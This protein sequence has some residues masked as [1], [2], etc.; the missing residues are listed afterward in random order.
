MPASPAA[1]VKEEA[2]IVA[3]IEGTVENRP[4]SQPPYS[5]FSPARKKFILSIVVAKSFIAPVSAGIYMPLLP[6]LAED[7]N[8]SPTLINLTVTV[9]MLTFAVAPLFF[10]SLSDVGGRKPVYVLG[11]SIGIGANIAL[12]SAPAHYASFMVLRVIQAFGGSALYSLG[13]GTV[14][15]I[16]EPKQR[17]RAIS[18]YSLGPQLGPILG[19]V[20]G[21]LIAQ[22]STW[23][24]TFGFLAIFGGFCLLVSMFL[25]PETL[26]SRVGNG[27][28][29]DG[30]PWIQWPSFSERAEP[31]AGEVVLRRPSR[32]NIPIFMK[33][34]II[35]FSCIN[36][37]ILF[38]SYYCL[39][40]AFPTVLQER[41][42][43]NSGKIGAAYLAPG[44]SMTCGSVICGHLSD[45]A[46]RRHL[47]KTETEEAA[48]ERRLHL[49]FIGTA[50][51]PIGVLIY[52]WLGNFSIGVSGVIMSMAICGFA[53]S[54]TLSTNTT[55]V[56]L[57][58]PGQAATLVALTSLLRNPA[59]AIGAAVI[60]PLIK[61]EGFGWCFTGLAIFDLISTGIALLSLAKGPSWR[62]A[63]EKKH[64]RSIHR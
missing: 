2:D 28:I 23:R 56:T 16:F 53:L 37:S 8:V 27:A 11:L 3:T 36:V 61:A 45:W 55:Y 20:I 50:L 30:K 34:P 18:Y 29:H 41:Y 42:G 40:V 19:P 58:Q 25:L 49:Q 59:A 47:E 7:L 10:A 57:V 35:M 54:W 17:G 22:R 43:F 32:R 26:R 24:W 38:G 4:L 13:A 15:D 46:H 64:G 60:D 52:G 14:V 44:I 63:F 62:E 12:A 31:K 48:P 6:I 9:F 39:S 21:G 51:F 33:H 1:D 5:A